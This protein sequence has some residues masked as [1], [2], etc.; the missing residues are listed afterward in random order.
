MNRVTANFIVFILMSVGAFIALVTGIAHAGGAEL[1]CGGVQSGC[2]VIALK[3]NS[4]W[5]NVPIAFYGLALYMFVAFLA[6]FRA[7]IGLENSPKLGVG[8]WLM[9]AVGALISV[10]LVAHAYMNLKAT[11]LWCLASM[12]TMVIAFLVHTYATTTG[13]LGGKAPP[14]AAFMGVLSLAV[15]AGAGYGFSL[16]AEAPSTE[17]VENLKPVYDSTDVF[18]G[19]ENATITI[20]EFTDLYCPTCRSQHAWLMGE[21]GS[22]IEGGKVKLVVR[23]YPLPNL[24]PL[25]IEAALFAEWAREEGKFWEFF[26]AVHQIDDNEDKALLFKAIESIGLDVRFAETLL[27]DKAL[28]TPY[29]DRM[30]KDIDD[31]TAL[32]VEATPSWFVD[33]ADGQRQFAVGSGI[34]RL[35]GDPKF[36]SAIR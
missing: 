34:Q 20:T 7:A 18:L 24:H 28:R 32:G 13:K 12:I 5:F 21:L 23:H 19:D 25:A 27:A 1:P 15:I 10:G 14:F 31:G 30:Q 3:E 9:L 11:C 26:D 33:Y 22:L 2:D 4:H 29:V 6:M 8:I 35:V 16:R 36:Q 17:F